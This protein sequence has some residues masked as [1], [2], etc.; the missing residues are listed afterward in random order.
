VKPPLFTT[1]PFSTK[2]FG[3]GHAV[4]AA[5]LVFGTIA[6]AKGFIAHHEATKRERVARAENERGQYGK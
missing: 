2:S 3:P 1:K 5:A 4:G 6:I